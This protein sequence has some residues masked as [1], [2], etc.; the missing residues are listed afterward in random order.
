VVDGVWVAAV[1]AESTPFYP[2]VATGGTITEFTAPDGITYRVHSFTTVGSSEF[3][4]TQ[5]GSFNEADVL[6]VAGG[7]AGGSCGWSSKIGGAGGGAGG[8]WDLRGLLLSPSTYHL[9]VGQGGLG[10]TNSGSR[11]ENGEDSQFAS[12]T[13][14]GGGGGGSR[15]SSNST[16]HQ[17]GGDGGSGGGAGYVLNGAGKGTAEQGSDGG[18]TTVLS[19][20]GR[21]VAGGGGWAERG[22]N[23][24][25]GGHGGNGKLWLDETR[26]PVLCI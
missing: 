22:R 4:V 16:F 9:I 5:L 26:N 24:T 15:S 7:G 2:L 13:A 20:S 6:V 21:R 17:S 23:N 10:K 25:E 18:S 12:H 1:V 14:Y 19:G 8:I 3:E 11:G